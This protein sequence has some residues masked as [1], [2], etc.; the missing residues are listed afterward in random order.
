MNKIKSYLTSNRMFFSFAWKNH[1][2]Y[3]LFY[4]ITTLYSVFSNIFT[5]YLPNLSLTAFLEKKDFRLGV[6]Y[7]VAYISIIIIW[8]YVERKISLAQGL[9]T[10]AIT[11]EMKSKIY[12]KIGSNN[13]LAFEDNE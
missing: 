12:E 11:F 13:M 1:K 9:N 4:A 5:V 7:I 10:Q 8:S 2:S 3:Y 6:I